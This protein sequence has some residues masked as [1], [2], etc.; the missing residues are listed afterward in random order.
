MSRP[1]YTASSVYLA[2]DGLA[3]G[4][5]LSDLPDSDIHANR[6]EEMPG[7][8][9]IHVHVGPA[10]VS[11]NGPRADLLA[12]LARMRAALDAV[13]PRPADQPQGGEAA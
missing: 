7:R 10:R 13:P 8:L 5:R 6:H 2:I 12:L 4:E 1:P 11:F 9:G 3:A